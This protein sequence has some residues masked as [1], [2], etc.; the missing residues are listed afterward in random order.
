MRMGWRSRVDFEVLEYG[1]IAYLS[2]FCPLPITSTRTKSTFFIYIF[3]SG[4][5]LSPGLLVLRGG[6]GGHMRYS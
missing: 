6:M 3:K 4:Q 2:L 1:M 5:N